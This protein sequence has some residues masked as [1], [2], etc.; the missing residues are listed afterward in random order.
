MLLPSAFY[1][2]GYNVASSATISPNKLSVFVLFEAGSHVSQVRFK[3]TIMFMLGIQL[4][5]SGRTASA[6]N[7]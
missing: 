7:H 3:L 1:S 5:S 4:R 6:P 2:V